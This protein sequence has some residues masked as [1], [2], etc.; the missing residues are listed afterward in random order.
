MFLF[1][2]IALPVCAWVA[3]TDMS[4][5]RIPNKAVI[6]LL[7]GFVALAPVVLP[8]SDQ[9]W[10]WLQFAIVLVVGF[11][12]TCLRLIGAGDAK[13]FAVLSL[14]IAPTQWNL[15]LVILAL[16]LIACVVLHRTAKRISGIRSLL[17]NWQS[18]ERREF[19]MGFPMAVAFGAYLFVAQG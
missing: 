9:A 19:P 3:V 10:R 2:P 8:L 5:M 16:S 6:I 18:W 17:P 15:F 13:F 4:E 12:L 11:L 1:L 14:Y 7:I